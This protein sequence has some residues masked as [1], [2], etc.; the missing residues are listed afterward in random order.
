MLL[1]RN[2]GFAHPTLIGILFDRNDLNQAKSEI[3][4]QQHPV[5]N[6]SLISS[7]Q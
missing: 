1:S 3:T 6:S 5:F 2:L 4:T 7:S